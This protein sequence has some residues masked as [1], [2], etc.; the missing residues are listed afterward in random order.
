[1]STTLI[2][3]RGDSQKIDEFRYRK[4]DKHCLLGKGIY[5]TDD[6]KLA[7]TYRTKGLKL[8]SKIKLPPRASQVLF[9]GK[10]SCRGEAYEKAFINFCRDQ[11]RVYGY[12]YVHEKDK[13]YIKFC[14]QQRPIYNEMMQEGEIL[15][16]YQPGLWRDSTRTLV[17]KY[18][19]DPN[20]QSRYGFISEF[21]FDRSYFMRNVIHA[22]KPYIDQSFWEIMHDA[23]IKIGKGFDLP[24]ELYARINQPK[25]SIVQ[26]V[27]MVV[28][29]TFITD[30]FRYYK[31][32]E[33]VMKEYGVLGFEYYGGTRT[34]GRRHS[35]FCIWDEDFVN[36]H[37]VDVYR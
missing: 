2:L 26:A 10:A 19:N 18:K 16:E 5:L 34:N 3:Y 37:K 11:W 22:E 15:S 31:Q 12:P 17:V 25:Y 8:S 28:S 13:Q 27:D 32:I 33:E 29:G 6:I 21:H 23:G 14:Q 24:K 9:S 35:A 4:T 7:D 1:M 20:P 36:K 30:R